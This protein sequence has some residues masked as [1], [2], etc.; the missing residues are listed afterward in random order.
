MTHLPETR[1]H[2]KEWM[3]NTAEN[4]VR[5][6]DCNVCMV[7][8][9][10]I[11]AGIFYPLVALRDTPEVADVVKA[12]LQYLKVCHQV[13]AENVSIAGHSLGAH[14]GMLYGGFQSSDSQ[15]VL[16]HYAFLFSLSQLEWLVKLFLKKSVRYMVCD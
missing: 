1:F 14:I 2:S 15:T 8:W 12:F 13:N 6:G 11:S 9:K 10:S 7:D 4:W 3:T 5:N 16:T